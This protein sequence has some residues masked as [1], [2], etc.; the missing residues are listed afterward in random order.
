MELATDQLLAVVPLLEPLDVGVDVVEVVVV[1]LGQ[2]AHEGL[3]AFQVQSAG[4]VDVAAQRRQHVHVGLV[5]RRQRALV[6]VEVRQVRNE[7]VSH[8]EAHQHLDDVDPAQIHLYHEQSSIFHYS[9]SQ[10]GVSTTA[11]TQS[12]MMCSMSKAKGSFVFS[13]WNSSARYSRNSDRCSRWNVMASGDVT[14]FSFFLPPN[15]T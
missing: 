11:L 9:N 6:D 5:E 14:R 4:L 12:S 13:D 7:V 15:F 1:D 3:E 8:Q 2:P 10:L